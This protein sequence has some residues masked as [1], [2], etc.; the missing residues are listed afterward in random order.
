MQPLPAR[1]SQILWL[2]HCDYLDAFLTELAL[3]ST[4]IL[5]WLAGVIYVSKEFGF[6][7]CLK[8]NDN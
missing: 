4:N 1:T 5:F 6:L 7:S 2:P 3:R 8:S